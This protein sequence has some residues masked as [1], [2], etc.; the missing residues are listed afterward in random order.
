MVI[1]KIKI[2]I[3]GATGHIAKG[4]IYGFQGEDD[5]ELH[6]FARDRGKFDSFISE[7]TCRIASISDYTDLYNADYDAII[8]CVGIGDPGILR[9]SPSLIL[10][11]TEEFDNLVLNY[12]KKNNSTIYINLSSGAVFG[13]DFHEPVKEGTLT[14]L[15]MNNIL[16]SQFYSL[17]KINSEVKHRSLSNLSIIDLRV[18]GYFSRFI[19]LQKRYLL[20]E[21]LSCLKTREIFHTNSSNIIRDYI[22]FNDLVDLIK[23]CLINK[24]LNDA[25]D[26]YSK[27]PIA[28]FDILEFYKTNY[29][30]DYCIEKNGGLASITGNKDLYY[31]NNIKAQMLGYYPQ[32]T[33]LDC[34]TKE[35]Q[36]LMGY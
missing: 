3:L 28:K 35:T 17:A 29:G 14:I 33:S 22:H 21:I 27:K 7:T 19:E 24:K 20:N 2:G 9:E 36:A 12:L 26:V 1:N 11:I 32:L 23:I 31:S 30:L 18:F 8:N 34:I 13:S 25:F 6:L 10:S 15:D 16:P 5:Y 4:L